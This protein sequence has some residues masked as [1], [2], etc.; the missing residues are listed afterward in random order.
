WK[1][2]V[3][4]L[5]GFL[6]ILASVVWFGAIFYIHLFVK[7]SSLSSGL[8]KKERILGWMCIIVVGVTGIILTTYRLRS[9]DEIWSTTFGI[10]WII[11]VS[12]F[13]IMVIIAAIAT[14]RINRMLRKSHEKGQGDGLSSF[15]GKE[16]RPGRIAAEGYS[17]DVTE[18]KF[19][20][21]GV[22]M[23]RHYAG[24]DLT[25]SVADAPHGMEVFERVPKIGPIDLKK[26]T[27]KGPAMRVFI[28]MAYF[29]LLCMAGVL[30]CIAYWNWGPS[31]INK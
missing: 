29:I 17:Y 8:P 31:L 3:R 22:H 28:F 2:V 4:L 14:T 9:I 7:P 6:H 24:N 19:W 16:G 15:N 10:I 13:M 25:S 21:D 1:N 30:F 26:E 12:F 11:K 23:G 20:K 27:K 18:S 5:V